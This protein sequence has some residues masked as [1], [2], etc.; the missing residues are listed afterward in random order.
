M[1]KKNAKSKSSPGIAETLQAFLHNAWTR[2]AA[3]PRIAWFAAA[4]LLILPAGLGWGL[5][6]LESFVHALPRYDRPL[7]L[8][9]VELPDWLRIPENRHV[10]DVLARQLGLQSTDR[11]LDPQLAQRLGEALA[12]PNVGWIKAVEYVHVEPTGEVAVKCQFRQPSAW[13]R[14][15]QY[16]Y[17]VDNEGFRLPGAY[18]ANDCIGG[19]LLMIDGVAAPPPP[20]GA[21]WPG[22]DVAAGLQLSAQITSQP[23]RHQVSN[24]I[25]SNFSG[26]QDISRPH[27]ELGTDKNTRIW[28]GRP[29]DDPYSAEITAAQKLV[30]LNALFREKGRIDS[31]RS[32][33]NIMT[34]PD[35]V[36]MPDERR[37][38]AQAPLLRG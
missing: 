16:C 25:V 15:G 17:L 10:L 7:L 33:V 29:P 20:I 30:L 9:W 1:S 18:D 36:A 11:P 8:K 19:E 38:T 24:V 23:F 35:R 34:W 32:Y 3:V 22:G 14:C 26:R 13:V 27:L 6:R 4:V 12:D 5:G 31:G 21:Q 2:L 28:W 37:A